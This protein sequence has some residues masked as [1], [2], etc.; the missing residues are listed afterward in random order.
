MYN[1]PKAI[2]NGWMASPDHHQNIFRFPAGSIGVGVAWTPSGY[3][4]WIQQF[5]GQWIE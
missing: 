2:V 4:H 1:D 3:P 5:S